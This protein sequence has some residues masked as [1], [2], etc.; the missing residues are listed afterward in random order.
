VEA[1][2]NAQ[3][4]QATKAIWMPVNPIDEEMIKLDNVLK[5]KA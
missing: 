5:N 4:Q 1:S 3:Y 2:G